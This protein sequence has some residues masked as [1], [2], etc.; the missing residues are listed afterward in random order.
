MRLPAIISGWGSKTPALAKSG[1]PALPIRA[2]LARAPVGIPTDAKP[3]ILLGN[4]I[5]FLFFGVLGTW[6][7][8]APLASAVLA[9]GVI[10]VKGNN[11]VVQHPD[12]GVVRE[13]L[14]KEGDE[15]REGQLLIRLDDVQA[16]AAVQQLRSQYYSLVAVNAR[17]R[18][19]RDGLPKIVFPQELIDRGSH[20]EVAEIMSGQENLFEGRRRSLEGQTS[21]FQ[22][23]IAQLRE[24]ARGAGIQQRALDQQLGF[25]NEELKGTRYLAQQGYAAQFK[26]LQLE[27]QAAAMAGQRGEYAAAQ[28]RLQQSIGETDLQILQLQKDRMS[29]V[30]S[31]L[32]DSQDKISSIVERLRAAEDILKRT[33]I[34]ATA[35]G[36]VLG[37]T[38]F[39]V[40]GVIDRSARILEIV[41]V[42]SP[43]IVEATI[44]PE[45]VVGLHEGMPAEIR[46][47]AYKQRDIGFVR[48]RVLQIS[49]DRFMKPNDVQGHYSITVEMSDDWRSMPE[50]KLMPGMP[51]MVSVPTKE[52]TVLQYFIGPFTD[53]IGRSM[54]EK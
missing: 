22:Q 50:V 43:L 10:K 44:K 51:A 2:T 15:V 49:A 30:T 14:V 31:Q 12:G 8:T 5:I 53:Y 28:A 32:T 25:L 34:T 23:R 17:L 41:S 27:R 33:L 26:V 40:G 39:T 6:A 42:N 19:E 13:L 20:P 36:I 38:A 11:K 7:A 37:M 4:L 29:E 21:V 18:A 54:R 24:Q 52:R 35:D 1:L 9:T 16:Q 45:D 47:T 48:G 3:V 46:L